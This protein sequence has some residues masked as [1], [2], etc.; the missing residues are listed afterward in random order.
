MSWVVLSFYVGLA[1]TSTGGSDYLVLFHDARDGSMVLKTCWAGP[2]GADVGIR[3]PAP[4]GAPDSCWCYF[5]E[6]VAHM[7][8]FTVQPYNAAGLAEVKSAA[9]M[10][11]KVPRDQLLAWAYDNGREP[12]APTLGVR[13]WAWASTFPIEQFSPPGPDPS[14]D[15][16]W[17]TLPVRMPSPAL[18]IKTQDEIQT[19]HAARICELWRR[20]TEI[21]WLPI[22]ETPGDTVHVPWTGWMLGGVYVPCP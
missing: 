13:R 18:R 6:S 19:D 2:S 22:T 11:T 1:F 5:T 14:R 20:Y 12:P 17:T 3:T 16:G 8:A 4:A 21:G 15:V 9:Y 10:A 7:G